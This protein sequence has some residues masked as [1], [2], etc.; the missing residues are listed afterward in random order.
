MILN[1]LFYSPFSIRSTRKS[2]RPTSWHPADATSAAKPD[3]SSSSPTAATALRAPRLSPGGATANADRPPPGHPSM[4]HAPPM[5]SSES[6]SMASYSSFQSLQNLSGSKSTT[7]L[8][9][10]GMAQNTHMPPSM[11][12]HGG[13]ASSQPVLNRPPPVEPRRKGMLHSNNGNSGYGGNS[14][15]SG[16]EAY[17]SARSR[18]GTFPEADDQSGGFLSYSQSQSQLYSGHSQHPLPPPQAA[19]VAHSMQDIRQGK[20]YTYPS[21]SR[22]TPYK[23]NNYENIDAFESAKNNAAAGLPHH[24]I[25]A[26]AYSHSYTNFTPSSRGSLSEGP[27]GYQ[28]EDDLPPDIPPWPRPEHIDHRKMLSEDSGVELSIISPA[29]PLPPGREDSRAHRDYLMKPGRANER[30]SSWPLAYGQHPLEEGQEEDGDNAR[31]GPKAH[32]WATASS[33]QP[34]LNAHPED[35]QNKNFPTSSSSS[36]H[37]VIGNG[38]SHRTTGS[39]SS[40]SGPGGYGA[41]DTKGDVEIKNLYNAKPSYPGYPGYDANYDV[42][43]GNTTKDPK[44]QKPSPGTSA[45]DDLFQYQSR[46]L[47]GHS[48]PTGHSQSSPPPP[49]PQTAPPL[50][51][52]APPLPQTS[53][54]SVPPLP[55]TAP[56]PMPPKSRSASSSSSGHTII[57]RQKPYYN[58]ATQTEVGQS[59]PPPAPTATQ[60]F[61]TPSPRTT[62]EPAYRNVEIQVNMD[63]VMVTPMVTPMS[64]LERRKHKKADQ[65]CQVQPSMLPE[66]LSNSLT[67]LNQQPPQDPGN[68]ADVNSFH[69]TAPIVDKMTQE[70]RIPETIREESSPKKYENVHIAQQMCSPTQEVKDSILQSIHDHSPSQTSIMRKLSREFFGNQMKSGYSSHPSLLTVPEAQQPQ[71]Q[72]QQQR[73]RTVDPPLLRQSKEYWSP[74]EPLTPESNNKVL[75][76]K[77]PQSGEQLSNKEGEGQKEGGKKKMDRSKKLSLRKAFGIF[78]EIEPAE[79]ANNRRYLSSHGKSMS[80]SHVG[81]TS[82]APPFYPETTKG[83]AAPQGEEKPLRWYNRPKGDEVH[84]ELGLHQRYD[85][86]HF[87]Q[88]ESSSIKGPQKFTDNNVKKLHRTSSEQIR[89]VKERIAER[90]R[91]LVEQQQQQQQ[92]KSPEIQMRERRQKLAEIPTQRH[93][94]SD[95]LEYHGKAGGSGNTEGTVHRS[96]DPSMEEY[97]KAT[98]HRLSDPSSSQREKRLSGDSDMFSRSSYE[99]SLQ[100]RPGSVRSTSSSSL[101]G[102]RISDPDIKKMQ[103]MAVLSFFEM[104]TGKR[105]SSSSMESGSRS[106]GADKYGSLSSRGSSSIDSAVC[107]YPERSPSPHKLSEDASTS[108][109]GFLNAMKK[110]KSLP[111]DMAGHAD[112]GLSL[113]QDSSALTPQASSSRPTSASSGAGPARE[114]RRSAG[115]RWAHH[116]K[117]RSAPS[118]ME[119]YQV[120]APIE[121]ADIEGRSRGSLSNDP[122]YHPAAPSDSTSVTTRRIA[123]SQV[124]RN[125]LFVQ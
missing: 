123:D 84:K 85:S 33:Y 122:S 30:M 92:P 6:L 124:S 10:G 12:W 101:D 51:Q 28:R 74:G 71:T 97:R 96:S 39:S 68:Y 18:A 121:R 14:N 88:E 13:V 66:T 34:R 4:Q 20:D 52:T 78:D 56:P 105:L 54:P 109:Q 44:L 79:D 95:P 7:S 21:W 70:K 27:E 19:P 22:P 102:H 50:P 90:E 89:P 110:S 76:N 104:K 3:V 112:E 16:R 106:S 108:D 29:P 53:P 81:N 35:R 118:Q 80:A 107:L 9:G 48:T 62:P 61:T 5:S 25:Q 114:R 69:R 63:L 91:S 98:Q 45:V 115:S 83:E 119:S 26:Q 11:S 2:D 103:H 31:T 40:S 111:R 86:G 113:P 59:P 125:L 58:T 116:E 49:L 37:A 93:K 72:T 46:D 17:P 77:P 67:N 64:T 120:V 47:S 60:Y 100:R 41:V 65:G 38:D 73:R 15:S 75:T 87:S 99:S 8:G 117:E 82:R 24:P 55:Q 42:F 1:S 43:N 94:N 32:S 36:Q 57:V 23:P